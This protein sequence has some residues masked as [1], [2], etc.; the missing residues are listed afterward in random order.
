MACFNEEGIVPYTSDSLTIIVILSRS[1]SMS[2]EIQEVS[3]GSSAHDLGADERT[4]SLTSEVDSIEISHR[5]SRKSVKT[6]FL[7][8]SQIKFVSDVRYFRAKKINEKVVN[9]R[10]WNIVW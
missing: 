2:C 9:F 3:E 5:I 6:G 7:M 10:I 8:T 1:L 4:S